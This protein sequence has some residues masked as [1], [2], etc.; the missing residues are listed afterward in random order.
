MQAVVS[1][2]DQDHDVRIEGLWHK[3]EQRFGLCGMTI[4]FPHF[5]YHASERYN[6]LV[7]EQALQRVAAHTD[8]FTVMTEGLAIFTGAAP[9][10][11]IPIVRSPQLN[12]FHCALYQEL[13]ECAIGTSLYYTPERWMPH[14]TLAIGDLHN[15]TLA[16]AVRWLSERTFTWT[17]AIDNLILIADTSVKHAPALQVSL[18]GNT[19]SDTT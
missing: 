13:A 6:P 1:K 19:R 12:L 5:T 14:I 7:I 3:L 16:E 9:V 4:S 18:G 11:T 8:S 2:L 17:I 10:L 15:D